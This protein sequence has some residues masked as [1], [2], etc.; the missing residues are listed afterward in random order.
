M[1]LREEE[2]RARLLKSRAE[3]LPDIKKQFEEAQNRN[4]NS[5]FAP[6]GKDAELV[7][8]KAKKGKNAGKA[9]KNA[10]NG[11]KS[12]AKTQKSAKNAAKTEAEKRKVNLSVSTRKGEM[13]HHQRMLSQD[14][15]AQATQHIIGVPVNKSRYNGYGGNQVTNAQ[16]K[17]ARPD[18][19]SV[20]IIPIGGL[21][22]FGIG[23]NMTLI[24]YKSEIIVVDMGVLFAGDD[25][26]GVNYMIPDIKYLEDNRDKVKAIC[27]T[28]AH[29]DHIGACKHLL[30]KFSKLTPIYG[31]DFTIGMIKRQISELDDAPDM[32]YQVVDPFKHEKLQVSEHMSVEFIHTLHSIP[33]NAAIVVWTPNGV[34][35]LSGDWRHE[36]RPMGVQT[37]YERIDEIVKNEGIT[38]M[39]NES[40]NIDSPGRHPHS[41]YDVGENLG[42]VMDHYVNGRVIISCFSSQILRIELILKEAAKR[43][44]KVA[45]SGFSMINNVEVALRAKSIKVPKDTVVKMED[46]VKMPDEKVCIVCTGSQGELNAVLNRM[47]S[48]AHKYIKIKSTDTIVFSSNPIPGNEPHVVN[49]VDGLLRE[50]AQVIQN[51]KTHLT[52]IGPLHLSGHAYYEDHVEFVTRMRPL[53]Y[54]PYHGEF[55]MLEHNAEMAENVVGIPKDRILISDDGDVVELTKDKK[56]RKCGRIHVGNK[57]YDDADQPVHE[58][59]VKDRIHISREGIFVIVLTLNKKTGHLMKTPD[60]VSR[61]FIYLDN[62]EELIGK[63]RHYLRQKTDKSI[64]TDPEMKV[65]KEEIKEDITH[66]LFDATGHTPIVIPVINKV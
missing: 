29:L 55:Y 42:R 23:K 19:E 20:R 10:S 12:N 6:G 33:G 15:N 25:Y 7:G 52:N 54:M 21:G 45:F 1:N 34:I 46:I 48:G 13:V 3:R 32:N 14:V 38:L 60:I 44:R 18:P 17:S 35:Y 62:S 31:T 50:G 8:G 43:G 51:G 64:S 58:A 66:I 47:V 39:L 2:R 57:L 22:E 65:L 26:P 56:I 16:L 27:F 53:N 28:H 4:F 11:K 5:N 59:V 37:D 41:E 9:L 24:E 30:P 40:T 61:A 63:I 49:T 36:T